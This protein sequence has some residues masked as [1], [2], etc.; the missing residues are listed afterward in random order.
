M[1]KLKRFVVFLFVLVIVIPLASLAMTSL[2][3]GD[4][5]DKNIDTSELED[6]SHTHKDG[7]KNILIMGTDARPGE[8]VSRSDS[9]MM[10]TIDTIHNDIKITSFARDSFVKIPGYGMSKLTHAYAYG[11]EGLLIKTIENNFDIDIDDFVLINFDS[12]IAIIDSLDGVTV[13]VNKGEMKEM[14]KFIPETYEWSK[15]QDKGP[16]KL[17]ENTGEQKLN[18]YQA[19]A[20]A[21]IRH[22]DSAF[23]RDNRQRM[24]VSSIMKEVKNSSK[25][26]Y[27]ALLKA[28]TP[29]IKTNMSSKDI[30]GYG[31]NVMGLDTSEV[32]QLEF[33]LV[34]NPKYAQGG[35]YGNHGWVVRFEKS[36]IKILHDFVF[37]DISYKE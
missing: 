28:A 7:I 37:D 11:K 30:L 35:I 15:N 1:S 8:K 17:V 24:I 31:L 34:D 13:N 29:Y 36:S 23:G 9:M 3:F 12:F 14:N 4:M 6:Y 16:M 20:F 2:L 5:H 19:L 25:L 22:N 26:K 10:L 21:R 18:G 33:P 27:P 32:K